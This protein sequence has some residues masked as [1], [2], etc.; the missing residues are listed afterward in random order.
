MINV[1]WGDT[2]RESAIILHH[3]KSLDIL[4]GSSV[5]F[6]SFSF[7]VQAPV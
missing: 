5:V 6:R 3:I 2:A 4:P 1:L 7:G